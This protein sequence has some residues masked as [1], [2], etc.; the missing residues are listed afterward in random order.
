MK[1]HKIT[2]FP[3]FLPEPSAENGVDCVVTVISGEIEINSASCEGM[4]LKL[5]RDQ[6][7][8]CLILV[9]YK[10]DEILDADL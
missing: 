6:E 3:G 4:P 2:V 10:L 7:D 8:E 1:K 5:S 9:Q